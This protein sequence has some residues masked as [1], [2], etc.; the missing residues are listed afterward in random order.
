MAS[1]VKWKEK[2]NMTYYLPSGSLQNVRQDRTILHWQQHQWSGKAQWP[3]D[4]NA[5]EWVR[6]PHGAVTLGQPEVSLGK[7]GSK[8]CMHC[9]RN[10]FKLLQGSLSQ[11]CKVS[12][13]PLPHGLHV[14]V[15]RHPL[16]RSQQILE[17]FWSEQNKIQ[18]EHDGNDFS[19]QKIC[20][21][22]S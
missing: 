2:L 17:Y 7:S 20:F 18:M 15:N 13:S 4:T 21:C 11:W 6:K 8:A 1:I 3:L 5:Q 9:W 19:P 10:K 14:E 22:Q 12:Q 16:K